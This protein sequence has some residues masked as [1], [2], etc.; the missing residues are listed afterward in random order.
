MWKSIL[1]ACFCLLLGV[2]VSSAQI[3]AELPV[4]TVKGKD[5]F[6]TEC[7]AGN[8]VKITRVDEVALVP[9]DSQGNASLLQEKYAAAF[10]EGN[11]VKFMV[12]DGFGFRFR[13]PKIEPGDKLLVEAVMK[14]PQFVKKS[15]GADEYFV[16]RTYEFTD[17][18]SE[19][20]QRI[21]WK[22]S[23]ESPEYHL[24]GTWIFEIYNR[25]VQLAVN[26]FY[27]AM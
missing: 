16:R 2:T 3:L 26:N 5:G 17:K 21:Y 20:V 4:E 6:I 23:K 12:N 10:F 24:S 15:E 22:F 19:S 14:L 11:I 25:G 18:D 27:V 9:A 1:F 13:L 8:F 7:K